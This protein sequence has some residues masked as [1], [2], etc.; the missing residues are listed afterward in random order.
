VRPLQG[1]G[2]APRSTSGKQ[3][4]GVC[5]F[6]FA[7]AGANALKSPEFGQNQDFA[8]ILDKKHLKTK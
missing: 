1:A 6:C 3:S 7:R 8:G 2:E 4:G 5:G